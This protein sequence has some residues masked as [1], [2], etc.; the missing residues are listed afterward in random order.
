MKGLAAESFYVLC[1]CSDSP[2][3]PLQDSP[4]FWFLSFGLDSACLPVC[5]DTGLPGIT[6]YKNKIKRNVSVAQYTL[7]YVLASKS[8]KVKNRMKRKITKVFLNVRRSSLIHTRW[9]INQKLWLHPFF[10]LP[11][12]S[13][14]S[15]Y[16][17]C[18][19]H[20]IEKHRLRF[21]SITKIFSET[22]CK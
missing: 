11:L 12:H 8:L 4:V 14:T 2:I 15:C 20:T 21:Q 22:I 13:S 17:W 18:S 9:M 16:S 10:S 19:F 6:I 5:G 3:N 7:F 1:C